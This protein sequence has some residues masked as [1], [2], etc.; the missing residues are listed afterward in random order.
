MASGLL[1]DGKL[2]Q[3][4]CFAVL[5]EIWCRRLSLTFISAVSVLCNGMYLDLNVLQILYY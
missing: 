4:I 3:P 5:A 2:I 1:A